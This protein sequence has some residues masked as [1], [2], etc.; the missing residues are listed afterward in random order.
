MQLKENLGL[1]YWAN[2]NMNSAGDKAKE[3]I[4]KRRQQKN[5]ACQIFRKANISYPLIRT[6]TFFGKFGV[7]CFLVSSVLRFALLPHH[8]RF[9]HEI[10]VLPQRCY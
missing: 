4:S 8:R 10:D 7:P 6:R 2:V 3:R 5:K 1:V 9:L